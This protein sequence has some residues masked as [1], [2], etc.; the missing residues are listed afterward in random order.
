MLTFATYY[1]LK[2]PEALRK[3]REEIDSVV[4]DEEIRLEHLSK[5]PYLIGTHTLRKHRVINGVTDKSTTVT[6]FAAVMRETLRLAPTASSRTC[7]ACEDTFLVG[8]DGDPTNFANK[9]F[10]VKKDVMITV[11]GFQAMRD[12]RVWGED[13]EQFKPE[14]MLDGKFEKLPVS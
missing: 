10:E 11:H 7:T 13:A 2:N 1:L 8:G 14:R 5:L 4:G 3:L 6:I 12:P 9:K